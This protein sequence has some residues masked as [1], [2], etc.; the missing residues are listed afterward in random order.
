MSTPAAVSASPLIMCL[1]QDRN[2]KGTS[3]TKLE[4]A[5]MSLM[6][7]LQGCKQRSGMCKHEKMMLVMVVM[8]IVGAGA[9]LFFS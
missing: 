9:Y 4:G 3:F 5:P 6:C 7:T 8:L 2:G 1:S